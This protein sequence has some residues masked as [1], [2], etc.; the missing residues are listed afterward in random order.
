MV[1]VDISDQTV[2]ITI[3]LHNALYAWFQMTKLGLFVLIYFCGLLY[4]RVKRYF[5][6][7][8][9]RTTANRENTAKPKCNYKLYHV[10]LGP[11]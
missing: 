2:T 7:A 8:E 10:I 11:K 6:L 4:S 9:T 1:C 3:V 5:I